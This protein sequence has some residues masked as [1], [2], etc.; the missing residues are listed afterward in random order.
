MPSAS[1]AS[2]PM[3]TSVTPLA[4][5]NDT[6]SATLAAAVNSTRQAALVSAAEAWLVIST[7]SA[8]RPCASFHTS[9]CSRPPLPTTRILRGAMVRAAGGAGRAGSSWSAIS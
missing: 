1:G 2:G 4:V 9:A 3:T 8:P 5:A 6:S 7:S